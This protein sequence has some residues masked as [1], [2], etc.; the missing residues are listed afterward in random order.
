MKEENIDEMD[1]TKTDTVDYRIIANENTL[2]KSQ[3]F[4]QL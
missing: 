4:D 1:E 3:S 2:P